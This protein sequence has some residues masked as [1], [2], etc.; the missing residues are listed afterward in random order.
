[1]LGWCFCLILGSLYIPQ[2]WDRCKPQTSNHQ[3]INYPFSSLK[4]SEQNNF[5]PLTRL[6]GFKIASNWYWHILH[7]TWID[8]GAGEA[9][10][11]ALKTRGFTGG[12]NIYTNLA[13]HEWFLLSKRA[14]NKTKFLVISKRSSTDVLRCGSI[15]CPFAKVW[16]WKKTSKDIQRLA[17]TEYNHYMF[18]M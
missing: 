12:A 14:M 1:M 3:L 4:V 7:W 17:W 15:W 5:W 16:Y 11:H 10:A 9:R 18:D 2:V 6:S 13:T 8:R